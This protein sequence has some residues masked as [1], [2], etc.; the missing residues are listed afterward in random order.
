MRF[1]LSSSAS[2]FEGLGFC[3]AFRVS[4]A[5]FSGRIGAYWMFRRSAPRTV[6]LKL[7]P[8]FAQTLQFSLIKE[9]T[10]FLL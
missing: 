3:K 1:P 4:L 2:F 9:Y 8:S 5:G 7:R 6:D 10:G